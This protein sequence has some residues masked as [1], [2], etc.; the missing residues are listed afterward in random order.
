MTKSIRIL[1]Y[2]LNIGV[3]EALN[4]FQL[5]WL[6]RFELYSFSHMLAPLSSLVCRTWQ[7][8]IIA[9]SSDCHPCHEIDLLGIVIHARI[10]VIDTL[11][12]DIQ[13]LF[14]EFLGH[15]G[16]IGIYLRAQI[17]SHK[18]FRYF[19][20]IV[21]LFIHPCCFLF[22]NPFIL[23]GNLDP[24]SHLKLLK[25]FRRELNLSDPIPEHLIVMIQ[26][27]L[28]KNIIFEDHTTKSSTNSSLLVKT[29][30]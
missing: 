5:L 10:R 3:V 2:N 26:D 17:F 22:Q 9:G 18:I 14:F 8:I 24:F 1:F 29:K 30:S 7:R 19:L 20:P 23:L 13:R 11:T 21:H 4:F 6:E 16:D 27:R 15:G 12:H 25:I 28:L